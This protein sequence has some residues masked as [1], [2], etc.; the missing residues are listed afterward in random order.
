MPVTPAVEDLVRRYPVMRRK[1][2]ALERALGKLDEKRLDVIEGGMGVA[3]HT[4][5]HG[6][7]GSSIYSD[8]TARKAEQ[9]VRLE[10]MER[11]AREEY[12]HL[13]LVVSAIDV[14]LPE[15]SDLRTLIDVWY[16][17]DGG[18]AAAARKLNFSEK[19]AQ[20]RR[21]Q[22]LGAIAAELP[23]RTVVVG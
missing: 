9:L 20:R 16:W 7:T 4:Q 12:I 2:E 18:R 1:L 6:R 3:L 17:Q 22:V 21:D 13:A 10:G 8:P 19:T 14:V 11:A 23:R 15:G 5:S